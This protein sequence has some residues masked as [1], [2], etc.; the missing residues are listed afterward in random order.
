MTPSGKINNL[1]LNRM[2]VRLLLCAVALSFP[3]S[4]QTQLV[5]LRHWSGQGISPAY[6][7]YDTNEDGSFN[8]WFG[9]MNRN[10]EETPDIPVGPDNNFSPGPADRGQPTHFLAR[11]HKDVFSVRVPKDFVGQTLTWTVKANGDTQKV[12]A[13]LGPQWM[14]DRKWT[15]RGANIENPYSNLPPVVTVPGPQ[16]VSA[17]EPLTLAISATDDGRPVRQGKP[18]GLTF[19]W[20]MY[21]GPGKVTFDPVEQK[22][23]DGKGTTTARFSAPGEY[24]LQVVVDDGSGENA[25]NFGYHCCWTNA[26]VKVTVK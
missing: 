20:G 21:R 7:G 16:L 18:I 22:M 3:L 8:M 17:S 6:E 19:A 13:S 9:Y 11:R 12:V 2:N 1:I 14:I 24:I 23:A 5:N 10:Y 25:G 15:T 4:A 26:Q